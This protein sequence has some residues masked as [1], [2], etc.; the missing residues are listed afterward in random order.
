M[1]TIEDRNGDEEQGVLNPDTARL[2]QENKMR[3][4][5]E[6]QMKLAGKL[7]GG[8]SWFY[9]VAALSIINSVIVLANGNWSFLFGLGVT[10]IVDGLVVGVVAEAPNMANVARFFGFGLILLISGLYVTFGWFANKRKRWAFIVGMVLYG[11]DSL[12]LLPVADYLG[13]AFHIWVLFGLFGGLRACG[14]LQAQDNEEL[15]LSRT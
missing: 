3:E 9:W 11:L 13:F 4:K 12:I 10:Q 14:E 5:I 15:E 2:D 7:K 1:M 8:A 6:A